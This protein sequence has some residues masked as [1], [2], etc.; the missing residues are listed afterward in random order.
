MPYEGI[1]PSLSEVAILDAHLC[2]KSYIEGF[3]PSQADATVYA[4]HKASAPKAAEYPHAARWFKHIASLASLVDLPG[5]KKAI[6]AIAVTAQAKPAAAEDEDEIDLFGSDEEED[7]ENE[8]LKA[9]R[10]A[11]YNAKKALKPKTIAK[12]MV[13]LDC[14]PWDDETDMK[15][16]EAGVRAIEMEG[17]L[18]GTGKLVAVGYGIKKLQITCVIEDAKVSTDDLVD[19]IC[20][21]EDYVQSVDISAFNKL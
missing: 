20:E 3:T 10:V 8:K 17:L 19:K 12:S 5:E 16:L 15:A 7:A 4:A 11:E 21:L 2:D 9:Q 13:I 18:W 14:K 1:M 6:D